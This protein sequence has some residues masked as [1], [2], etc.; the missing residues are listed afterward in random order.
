MANTRI[1]VK[2]TTVSGRTPNTTNAA[3]TQYIAAG[4]LALNLTDGVLYS[5]NGTGLIT[6]GATQSTI[7][8]NSVVSNTVSANTVSATNVTITNGISVGNSTVNSSIN[9]TALFSGNS[10]VNTVVNT[11]FISVSNAI[12]NSSLSPQ[13]VFVGNSSANAQ[14]NL[15]GG[16]RSI[17][18]TSYSLTAA[19]VAT[20]Q[21]QVNHGIILTPGYTATLAGV[22]SM[23]DGRALKVTSIPTS[24]TFTFSFSATDLGSL[25]VIAVQRANG[26]QTYTTPSP[27]GLTAGQSVTITGIPLDANRFNLTGTIASAPTTNTFTISVSS[28]VNFT[29]NLTT[30]TASSLPAGAT[31]DVPLV[32][33]LTAAL[34]SHIKSLYYAQATFT[35][36]TTPTGS[37]IPYSTGTTTVYSDD[38]TLKSRKVFTY[39][40]DFGSVTRIAPVQSSL[41]PVHGKTDKAWSG[42]TGTFNT[43][44]QVSI[45]FDIA[46]TTLT[47]PG[48][49]TI[50]SIANTAT[51]PATANATLDNPINLTVANST[52]SVKV[53]PTSIFVGGGTT[54]VIIDAT[55]SR[56]NKAGSILQTFVDGTGFTVS[57]LQSTDGAIDSDANS[58]F[59][60]ASIVMLGNTTVSTLLT[61]NSIQSNT[62]YAIDSNDSTTINSSAITM[63]SGLYINNF[64]ASF[65]G[66]VSVGSTLELTGGIG[67]NG[68][69]GSDGNILTSNGTGVY[70]SSAISANVNASTINATAN[71]ITPTLYGNVVG[72]T[73]NASS[74]V[75]TTNVY[76]TT[77]SANLIGGTANLSTSVNSALLTV[78]TSLIANTTGAYHTGTINAASHTVGS[79]FIANS[80]AIIGTGYANVTTSVN[81]ALLTVGTAFTANATLVNAAAINITGQ[82]NTA[83]LY[84]ATSA[85][86]GTAVVANATGVYTTGTV[87]AASLTVGSGFVANTS[88]LN[89]NTEVTLTV[90]N[91]KLA[92]A[93]VNSSANVYFIQQSDDNFVFY[94]TNT[95]YGPR[96]VWSIFAN[97]IT[98]NFNIQVRS[99]HNGGLTIPAGVTLL[100]STGSQGT[101]GQVLTTNGSSNVY[102]STVTSGSSSTNTAAQYIWSNTQTFQA[103]ITFSNTIL[104]TTVNAATFSV[105]SNFIANTTQVTLSGVA[106]SANATIGTS[107]Q[108]L[109]SNGTSV[110]WASVGTPRVTAIASATSITPNSDSTDLVTQINTG[111]AGTLTINAPTGTPSDGQRLMFR[112]QSTNVQTLSFNAA[113]DASVDLALPTA[114]SGASRYDYIGFMYNSTQTKWNIVAK[115]FGF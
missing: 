95:A 60:N 32:I 62:F 26:V 111:V 88:R 3:N 8:T 37:K 91:K 35:N 24:N 101:A 99:S 102:W 86:I 68:D 52:S 25:S 74:N 38:I 85:N 77:V 61:P 55:G 17:N 31:Q 72:T 9:S 103:N 13:I 45:G 93:T 54:N 73:L 4:E 29:A 50:G 90:N 84:A 92:F 94:S 87:N 47:T 6:I 53:T 109:S 34:P 16:I 22:K 67:A 39:P 43:G 96:A 1:Q 112:I 27:H 78:G 33:N 49:I 113:Y 71:V 30:W 81:S 19:G 89:S 5:S 21:T 75:I 105:G 41:P 104:G 44:A 97:S 115:N 14:L 42:S 108:V 83:T 12:T 100:D 80:T 107:G 63:S 79:S 28:L 76:A 98:S 46:L 15:T 36:V 57:S 59:A 11:V 2:R 10:S 106:V 18:V 7:T 110:Y 66:I 20:I 48:K 70:W 56:F 23:F 114:T 82:V 40:N 69:V 51:T 64:T 65:P 58:Y